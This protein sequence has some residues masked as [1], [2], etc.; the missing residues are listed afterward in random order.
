MIKNSLVTHQGIDPQ[1]LSAFVFF[2]GGC[3]S[4]LLHGTYRFWWTELRDE[5]F[6]FFGC[7]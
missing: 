7:R 2:V 3:I 4:P 6:G 1:G 5:V